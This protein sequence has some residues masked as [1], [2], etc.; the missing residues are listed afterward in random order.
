MELNKVEVF[1]RNT[2]GLSETTRTVSAHIKIESRNYILFSAAATETCSLRIGK[3]IHF[4]KINDKIWCFKCDNSTN[5]YPIRKGKNTGNGK[6]SNSVRICCTAFIE[7]FTT[8]LN[9]KTPCSFYIDI[10]EG[11]THGSSQLYQILL[12]KPK[13]IKK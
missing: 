6:T 3:Y 13:I 7:M 9:L 8:K 11:A 4:L 10:L 5:G 12:D 2:K 1:N